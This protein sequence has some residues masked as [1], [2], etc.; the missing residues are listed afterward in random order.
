MRL[1]LPIIDQRPIS[2]VHRSGIV[3][4]Q[5]AH[6]PANYKAQPAQMVLFTFPPGTRIARTPPSA[7]RPRMS[8][9]P[10]PGATTASK[11]WMES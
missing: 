11:S 5:L 9:P 4:V 3:N 7:S 10:S 2:G 1:N 6:M 8:P